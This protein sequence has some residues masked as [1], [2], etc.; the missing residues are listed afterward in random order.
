[1]SYVADEA[2]GSSIDWVKAKLDVRFTYAFE[3]RDTGYYGF[4][5]PSSEIIP[6]GEETLSSVI[7]LIE[8]ADKRT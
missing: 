2:A 6:T 3:L 7:T 4:M 5:L 1:M 8:E